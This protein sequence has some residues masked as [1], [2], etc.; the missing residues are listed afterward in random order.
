MLSDMMCIG[1]ICLKTKDDTYLKKFKFMLKF[2]LRLIL[3]K[4]DMSKLANK[5]NYL[6]KTNAKRFNSLKPPLLSSFLNI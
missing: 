6:T 3:I 2:D 4:F 5:I 1:E